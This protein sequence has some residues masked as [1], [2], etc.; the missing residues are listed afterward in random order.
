MALFLFLVTYHFYTIGL[1][2][3]SYPPAC[4]GEQQGVDQVV[5]MFWLYHMEGEVL[6]QVRL[7]LLAF[8]GGVGT[9]AQR[10]IEY[11][12]CR[13]QAFVYISVSKGED[14]WLGDV[15]FVFVGH[16]FEVAL[17]F[18]SAQQVEVVEPW[19]QVSCLCH[20]CVS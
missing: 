7:A 19:L 3:E 17:L 15:G 18:V 5:R 14:G 2:P 9:D 4:L 11:S 20:R 12:F 13:L 6:L 16:H 8:P 10:N 1:A